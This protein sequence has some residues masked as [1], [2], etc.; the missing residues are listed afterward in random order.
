M[1]VK[2]LR[3]KFKGRFWWRRWGLCIEAIN[4]YIPQMYFWSHHI[5]SWII[6]TLWRK[7]FTFS[8]VESDFLS[9][10]VKGVK[11]VK[12][13]CLLSESYLGDDKVRLWS[14]IIEAYDLLLIGQWEN[15]WRKLRSNHKYVIKVIGG[16][17]S[18]MVLNIRAFIVNKTRIIVLNNV[19][20]L[21]RRIGLNARQLLISIYLY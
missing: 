18:W 1:G 7:R 8:L 12:D 13:I 21:I 16:E 6:S 15:P 2:V 20:S 4:N 9:K 10:S 3:V 11:N 5:L 14:D 17:S 19:I